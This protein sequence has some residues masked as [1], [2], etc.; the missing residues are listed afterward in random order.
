MKMVP[1]G[2]K[3]RVHFL[4]FVPFEDLPKI[5]RGADVYTSPAIGG[6]TFGLVLVEAMASGVPVVAAYNE[7]YINVIKDGENGILV[8][9]KDPN[10]YA[11]ALLKVLRDGSLRRKIIENGLKTA[12]EYSWEKVAERIEGVYLRVLGLS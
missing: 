11:E 10:N 6:E 3:N 5:Y 7:G 12:K 4:G 9:V 8:N 2:L 1:E